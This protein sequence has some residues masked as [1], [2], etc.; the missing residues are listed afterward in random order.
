MYEVYFDAKAMDKAVGHFRHAAR[1]RKEAI[2]FFLGGVYSW[3]GES[4]ARATDYVTAENDSTGV[5]VRFADSAFPKLAERIK[6]RGV[7][8]AWAHSHPGFGAF[9]SETDVA[10]H[11]SYFG[12][13]N[14][15]ALVVDPVRGEKKL[16]KIDGGEC[17]EAS[18]AVV[19]KK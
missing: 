1:Q 4:F 14:N 5:S 12:G 3:K 16:F 7:I 6:D 18:F 9:M 15:Y 8:V 10:T 13:G 11:E 2:G 19:R 17:V